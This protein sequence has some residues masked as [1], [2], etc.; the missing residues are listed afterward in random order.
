MPR[1]DKTG[2]MGNGPLTGR[3]MRNYA[4]NENTDLGFDSGF[5][6]RGRR[7]GRRGGR[8]YGHGFTFFNRDNKQGFTDEETIQ[9]EIYSL[10]NRLSFLENLVKKAKSDEK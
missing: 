10:K 8:G 1:G 2:P 3:R 7:I 5:A 6:T 4:T 9:N